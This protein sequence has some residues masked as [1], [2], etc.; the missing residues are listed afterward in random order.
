[1]CVP[2]NSHEEPLTP[3]SMVFGSRMFGKLLGLHEVMRVESL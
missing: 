1:M 2:Q 3:N